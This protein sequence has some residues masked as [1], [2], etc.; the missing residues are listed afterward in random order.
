[1]DS[2]IPSFDVSIE[3][4]D[5]LNLVNTRIAPFSLVSVQTLCSECTHHVRNQI[6]INISPLTRDQIMLWRYYLPTKSQWDDRSTHQP[7]C[8]EE[9]R[10]Q[11]R[12]SQNSCFFDRLEVWYSNETRI[13]DLI[14]IGV[15]NEG[16]YELAR[17]NV[18]GEANKT[19]DQVK[20]ILRKKVYESKLAGQYKRVVW[21]GA[22]ILIPLYFFALI[23][24]YALYRMFSD[25]EVSYGVV[26]VSL[27][28][29]SIL[30]V[31]F[32]MFGTEYRR[33]REDFK[34]FKSLTANLEG[35][36]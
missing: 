25:R 30:F 7:N 9:V 32:R 28:L 16:F 21:L 23:E 24:V 11:I 27:I 26:A 35:E 19:L 4:A 34:T 20:E 10:T 29:A 18:A 17:W 31:I 13:K 2:Y 14:L 22:C 8:P 5:M 12:K 1:M 33:R 3:H 15:R 36:V 6:N